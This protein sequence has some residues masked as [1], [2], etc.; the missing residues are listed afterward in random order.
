MLIG[1]EARPPPPAGAA[2]EAAA[3]DCLS[4]KLKTHSL[5]ALAHLEKHKRLEAVVHT[6]YGISGTRACLQLDPATFHP[7]RHPPKRIAPN[8]NPD[9]K[10]IRVFYVNAHALTTISEAPPARHLIGVAVTRHSHRP[11]IGGK[12][13][14][15]PIQIAVA[16]VTPTSVTSPSR[17]GSAVASARADSHRPIN[18]EHDGRGSC[19]FVLSCFYLLQLIAIYLRAP[20][21]IP[22]TASANAL[23]SRRDTTNFY[24]CKFASNRSCEKSFTGQP[25]GAY[26]AYHPS[27]TAQCLRVSC[28]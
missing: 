25:R 16:L 18:Q 14:K 26:A 19:S 6:A 1:R 2:P 8:A 24:E 21:A 13:R 12:S 4:R 28:S 23:D 22:P 7:H 5:C 15:V 9:F 20:S 11:N 10:C 3:H 27:A 17:S